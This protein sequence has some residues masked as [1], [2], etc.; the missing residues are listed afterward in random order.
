MSAPLPKELRDYFARFLREGLNGHE[1]SRRLH[2]LAVTGGGWARQ[3]RNT[4]A[5]TVAP[6][7]R[8][9]GTRKLD[10]H[11]QSAFNCDSYRRPIL[12][13]LRDGT[14]VGEEPQLDQLAGTIHPF[15]SMQIIP[16]CLS[17]VARGE[18]VFTTRWGGQTWTPISLLEGQ[19]RALFHN[20]HVGISP[21]LVRQDP[22]I[23]LF[24]QRDVLA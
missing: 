4:G 16:S 20:A 1:A 5:A 14:T 23:T 22:G 13:P 2:V 18:G 15:L 21:E 19:C 3:T 8:P 6:M 24:E 7:G 12:P 10:A 17:F 11:C 9:S